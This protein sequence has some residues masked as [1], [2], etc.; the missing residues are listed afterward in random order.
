M[1]SSRH[2]ATESAF[3]DTGGSASTHMA[4]A[5]ALVL[6]ARPRPLAHALHGLKTDASGSLCLLLCTCAPEP[7]SPIQAADREECLTQSRTWAVRMRATSRL[8]LRPSTKHWRTSWKLPGVAVRF[9]SARLAAYAAGG[10][11]GQGTGFRSGA[12]PKQ[13]APDPAVQS[14]AA[15]PRICSTVL[16]HPHSGVC[17]CR[18]S[19]WRSKDISANA[20]STCIAVVHA[21]G[22]ALAGSQ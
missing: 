18:M 11:C 14:Q 19:C 1:S 21:G 6:A 12:R 8:T 20:A 15:F 17:R 5:Y 4:P 7:A 16:F 3:T 22:S 13:S 9:T 2:V 10:S